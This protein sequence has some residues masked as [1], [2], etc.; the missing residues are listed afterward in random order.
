MTLRMASDARSA[1]T[2]SWKSRSAEET[3]R[4][5]AALAKTLL[6]GDVLALT[7]PLGAGK[8]RLV[9]GIARGLGW[10][11]DVRSPTFTLINEYHGRRML[12]H[13]DLYRVE[14]I[15]A[16]GL[17]LDEYLRRRIKNR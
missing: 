5:G 9:A 15:E 10:N 13:A 2:A 16:H 7:G 8:T 6:E 3:E 11:G 4:I 12:V 14:S 1:E 17:G